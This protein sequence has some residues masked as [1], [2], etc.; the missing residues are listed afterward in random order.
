MVVRSGASRRHFSSVVILE[1]F[2]GGVLIGL[3]GFALKAGVSELALDMSA[4]LGIILTPIL[5]IAAIIGL[6]GFLLMQKS[7]HGE[8]VSIVAPMIG[9]VSIILPVLLAYFFLGDIISELKW[10][11]IILIL[12]GVTALGK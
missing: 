4:I 1:M 3:A 5:W 12:V 11:G 7:L 9:G 10:V 8:K 6:A 2:A